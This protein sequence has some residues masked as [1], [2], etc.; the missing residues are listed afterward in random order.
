MLT[1]FDGALIDGPLDIDPAER[2]LLLGDGIFE[3]IAVINRKPVWFDAHLARMAAAAD[4]MGLALDE[5]ACRDAAQVLS[6]MAGDGPRVL[7]LTLMRGAG[8]RGLA[9]NGRPPRLLATLD[10]AYPKPFAEVTLAVSSVRR[11]EHAPSSRLKTLSYADSILAAREARSLGA[12]DAL[13]LNTAGFA[14]CSSIANLFLIKRHELVTPSPDQGVLPGIVRA[15]VL[16]LA[17]SVGLRPVER[18]VERHE[19]LAAEAVF[20]TNSLRFLRPVSSIDGT[21]L[22]T[23][24]CRPVVRALAAEAMQECGADPQLI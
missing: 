16:S 14:A 8:A 19:P 10:P 3:T 13:M 22:D 5:E 24:P 7:R 15:R 4:V 1:W 23:G 11:N 21:D 18:K 12:E 20:L 17:E 9:E 2:G 6:D